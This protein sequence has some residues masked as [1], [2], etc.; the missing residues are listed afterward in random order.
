[1]KYFPDIAEYNVDTCA[2]KAQYLAHMDIEPI[3]LLIEYNKLSLNSSI[4]V[5]GESIQK[6]DLTNQFR[7]SCACS[8]LQVIMAAR[9]APLTYQAIILMLMSLLEE[10]FKCWCRMIG[11]VD[12]MCPKFDTQFRSKKKGE[13]EKTF[14][15]IQKYAKVKDIECDE[16]WEKIRAIRAARNAIVHHGGRVPEKNRKLLEKYNIGM[17]EQ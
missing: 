5:L 7:E 3:K 2:G 15:Y 12:K 17:R 8:N 16:D 4:Q 14:D 1:M 9:V 6:Y 13:L 11:I 10:A